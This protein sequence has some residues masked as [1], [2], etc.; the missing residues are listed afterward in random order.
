MRIHLW[1]PV[2]SVHGM[3]AHSCVPPSAHAQTQGRRA[4]ASGG[5]IAPSC[6]TTFA[7]V[8]A[9]MLLNLPL[10]LVCR[11]IRRGFIQ[12]LPCLVSAVFSCLLENMTGCC[13][14]PEEKLAI[15]S[16]SLNNTCDTR[17]EHSS[18]LAPIQQMT[19]RRGR[20]T[21]P[22]LFL[23]CTFAA[24]WMCLAWTCNQKPGALH[25]AQKPGACLEGQT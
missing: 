7:D 5:S 6:R 15:A 16:C 21:S 12:T 23:Q 17:G 19:Y 1:W 9:S 20:L 13:I 18:P 24:A 10:C 4:L 25:T 11:G 8:A 2:N 14:S 3:R 22:Q